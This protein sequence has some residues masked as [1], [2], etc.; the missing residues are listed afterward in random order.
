MGEPGLVEDTRVL[1]VLYILVLLEQKVRNMLPFWSTSLANTLLSPPLWQTG[2]ITRP[3]SRVFPLLGELEEGDLLPSKVYWMSRF[4]TNGWY[5]FL[6]HT[7]GSTTK[8]PTSTPRR[9]WGSIGPRRVSSNDRRRRRPCV[10]ARQNRRA[11]T[12]AAVR[13]GRW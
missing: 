6:L 12:I 7:T 2:Y 4:L 13:L 8:M 9:N 1:R 5:L 3:Q 11:D 10:R